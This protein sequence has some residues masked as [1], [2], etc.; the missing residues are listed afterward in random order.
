MCG[1]AAVGMHDTTEGYA[2]ARAC[3]VR[4]GGDAG[5]PACAVCAATGRHH[6]GPSGGHRYH[7]A[8][9]MVRVCDATCC[10]AELRDGAQWGWTR[11]DGSVR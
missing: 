6:G 11:E 9:S 4:T 7:R 10:D 2:C 1:A 5:V 3:G 8:G